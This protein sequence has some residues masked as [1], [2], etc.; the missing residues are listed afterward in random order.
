V[1]AL[2]EV[3]GPA[4]V[5]VLALP[6]VEGLVLGLAQLVPPVLRVVLARELVLVLVGQELALGLVLVS[7]SV[8]GLALV[9]AP[10]E[11]QAGLALPQ[12]AQFHSL[13]ELQCHH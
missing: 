8:L 7:G 9:S 4:Q 1:L 11:Q 12:L 5:Q 6:Q 13:L 3:P 10:L 2:E